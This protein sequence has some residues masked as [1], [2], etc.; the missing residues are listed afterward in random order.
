MYLPKSTS[1]VPAGT[2]LGV[3][4]LSGQKTTTKHNNQ[5][6]VHECDEGGKGDKEIRRGGTVG[7]GRYHLLGTMELGVGVKN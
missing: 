2:D 5:P 1:F 4:L 7:E 3:K 6:K